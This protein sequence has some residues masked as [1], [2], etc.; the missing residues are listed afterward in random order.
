MLR[1]ANGAKG[2][3]KGNSVGYISLKPKHAP[4]RLRVVTCVCVLAKVILA[5]HSLFYFVLLCNTVCPTT[6]SYDRT[7][8]SHAH[9]QLSCMM[10]TI[11]R[12]RAYNRGAMSIATTT[13]MHASYTRCEC[14]IQSANAQDAC[15][16]R[17][18]TLPMQCCVHCVRSLTRIL[19][20]PAA[21]G[22]IIVRVK[23]TCSRQ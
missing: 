23:Y 22:R 16:E 19:C 7:H 15:C 3:G 17:C 18:R 1:S 10:T 11:I 6:L 9:V 4:G 20:E 12:V 14:M 21:A 13:F 5:A 2:N 8:L